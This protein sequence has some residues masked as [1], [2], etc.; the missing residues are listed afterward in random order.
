[1]RKPW[2]V[3][4]VAALLFAG[5]VCAL[6]AKDLKRALDH[7][8]NW[9]IEQF[10]PKEKV[11]GKGEYDKDVVTVAMCVKA[12]CDN[13]RDYRE[14]SG[15]FISEPVKYILS[16]IGQDGKLKGA[17]QRGPRPYVWVVEALKATKND[18]YN[19]VIQKCVEAS[20]VASKAD[21]PQKAT[22]NEAYDAILRKIAEAYGVSKAELEWMIEVQ[23]ATFAEMPIRGG[24]EGGV[25]EV[26]DPG[27][28][29]LT[30]HEKERVEARAVEILK[31]QR[32]DGSF[33]DLVRPHAAFLINL[34][35]SYKALK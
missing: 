6:E 34:N 4:A 33:N 12:L 1:M 16:Q 29:K 30:E 9:L 17:Q 3:L 15:P 19:A 27:S 21:T 18:A 20:G 11:F 10:D 23:R 14:A 5:R 2:H 26:V 22:K 25:E 35:L 13:P 31:L 24:T 7:G 28:A 32:E 8:V